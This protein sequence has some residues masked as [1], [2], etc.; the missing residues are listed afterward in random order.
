MVATQRRTLEQRE[1]HGVQSQFVDI[2]QWTDIQ[3]NVFHSI[4]PTMDDVS[5]TAERKFGVSDSAGM[6]ADIQRIIS[7]TGQPL[8]DKTLHQTWSRGHLDGKAI[9]PN[10]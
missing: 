6:K 10:I 8:V 7:C 5:Q 1:I 3:A 4:R 2:P 9:Q